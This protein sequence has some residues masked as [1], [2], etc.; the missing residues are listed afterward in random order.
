MDST[1]IFNEEH[2]NDNN[3][4]LFKINLAN[5]E[6]PS[7]RESKVNGIEYISFGEDNN[8]PKE[9]ENMYNEAS[10][11]SAILVKIAKGI[12][13]NGIRIA[14]ADKVS[15]YDKSYFYDKIFNNFSFDCSL[16]DLIKKSINDYCVFGAFALQTIYSRDRSKIV[17]VNH[18]APSTL[19][20]G[21]P[22][23][24]IIQHY[25]ICEDW[26]AAKRGSNKPIIYPVFNPN[27]VQKN[28]SQ[29]LY[30]K[31]YRV[32]Q[33]YYGLPNYIAGITW[34]KTSI[35]YA[36]YHLANTENSFNPSMHIALFGDFN[37]EQKQK[38][39]SDLNKKFKGVSNAGNIFLTL[40]KNKE[41][42]PVVNMLEAN[43]L[44]STF[45]VLN[46]QITQALISSHHLPS[47]SVLGFSKDLAIGSREDL[48][49]VNKIFENTVL[50]PMRKTIVDTFNRI[51]KNMGCN[52]QIELQ[53][54][55]IID[56]SFSE[57]VLSQ[58]LT[59]KEMRDIIG[60][61]ELDEKEL[62][63]LQAKLTAEQNKNKEI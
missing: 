17:Q 2:N 24:G 60:A 43:K 4:N 1:N 23:Q 48:D 41:F 36:K 14:D 53:P 12:F 46:E 52:V 62:N 61:K 50:K 59:V 28:Q 27:S 44:D 16:E 35:N 25:L 32:G 7:F 33:K 19:R 57:N 13:G 9:L 51:I 45:L 29:I 58:I 6:L 30:T 21:K 26:Q 31:D 11:H 54:N 18:V 56:Y 38:I 34:I 10:L 3:K 8:F 39:N 42:M 37:D 20:I 55:Q 15:D 40:S 63:A 47:I 49:N 5:V 22:E